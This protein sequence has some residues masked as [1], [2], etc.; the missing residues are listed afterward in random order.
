MEVLVTKQALIEQEGEDFLHKML[1]RKEFHQ[2][3]KLFVNQVLDTADL[4]K[5]DLRGNTCLTLAGKL[6]AKDEEY[7]KAVNYFFDK[8]ANGKRKN[9]DG[10]SLMHESIQ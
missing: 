8:K 2:I 10:W 4:D 9:R 1:F 6:C 7:L 5:Y 3:A